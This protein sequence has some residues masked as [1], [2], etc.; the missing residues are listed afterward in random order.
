MF[1]GDIIGDWREEMI[2]TNNT[3]SALV[4]FTTNV[5]SST[6]IYT[7][8]HNPAYRNCMTI[9][10]YMQSHH[11]DFYLG[12]GMATPPRP[13]ITYTATST[14]ALLAVEAIGGIRDFDLYPNP[15]NATSLTVN[16]SMDEDADVTLSVTD[17]Q[18]RLVFN[19]NLGMIRKGGYTT[20]IDNRLQ[21]GNYIVSMKTSKGV[22][23]KVFVKR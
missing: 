14:T 11:T 22:Q 5:A 2:C 15:L 18:G 6:R 12:N 10:G 3:Y 20:K 16:I 1:Y 23:S 4:I 9:K 13:N 8:A 21:P 19:K 7:L 17:E